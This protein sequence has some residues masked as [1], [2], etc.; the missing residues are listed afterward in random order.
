METHS[1]V[2]GR[3]KLECT[4]KITHAG[5]EPVITFQGKLNHQ[6]VP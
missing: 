4:C 1:L 6:Y 5:P 3:A 2:W